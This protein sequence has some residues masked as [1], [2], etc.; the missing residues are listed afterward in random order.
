MENFST[1]ISKLSLEADPSVIGEAFVAKTERNLAKNL[2][3]LFG[4]TDLCDLPDGFVD[5]FTEM[6]SDLKTEYY[7]PPFDIEEG[8]EKRFEECLQRANRRLNKIINESFEEIN[9]SGIHAI[10]GLIHKNKIYLSQI[11]HISAFLFHQRKQF[12]RIIIDILGVGADKKA[13]IDHEKMFSNIVSGAISEKDD[14]IICNSKVLEAV[15]QYD[16]LGLFSESQAEEVIPVKLEKLIESIGQKSNFYAIII[17]PD[18]E[19]V[20]QQSTGSLPINKNNQVP[21]LPS[22]NS[23]N[24]LLRTQ[25]KTEKYLT[26][27][28]MPSWQKILILLG[29]GIKK[30]SIFIWKYL[31]IVLIYINNYARKLFIIIK[32]KLF[33]KSAAKEIMPIIPGGASSQI[34]PMKPSE[35]FSEITQPDFQQMPAT[36]PLNIIS[37]WVNGQIAKIIRLNKLQKALLILALILIFAFSESIVWMGQASSNK[38]SPNDPQV[39]SLQI[40]DKL[41]LAEAQNI[42]NDEV[43]A[44]SYLQQARD[45][46]AK[47]PEKKKYQ[48]MRSDLLSKI[49]K[50]SQTIQKIS[51]LENPQLITDLT[52]DNAQ[53]K[54]M[55]LSGRILFVY[56][57]GNQILYQIDLD[58]KQINKSNI[59]QNLNIIKI[60][61]LD[62]KNLIILDNSGNLFKYTLKASTTD[63][64]LSG[65]ASDVS[66]YAGKIYILQK[67]KNQIIK[68][69]LVKN[70]L[71]TPSSLI[72]N[73]YNLANTSAISATVSGVLS[74]D[75]SG[76]IKYF[77]KGIPDNMPFTVI[78][79]AVKP[80]VQ[81]YGDSAGYIYLL[82]QTNKKVIIY[83]K[84]GELK[85]QI[86]STQFNSLDGMAVS[87]KDKKI[88]LLSGSKI[89]AI[90][91]NL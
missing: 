38:K 35:K 80:P 10:I 60:A 58:K 22:Q 39:I 2:G 82:D 28:L 87:E 45:L 40:E 91:T 57:N 6:I 74:F 78:D 33:K 85:V 34:E 32:N 52:A 48:S 68:Y 30:T 13:K 14:I 51:Y 23:I 63:P 65:S 90:N 75:N 55:A 83:D 12:D 72:K 16:L 11:G 77:K 5:K 31:K 70:K 67:D 62:A 59:P 89:F 8:L 86:T 9:L 64:L 19:E 3:L 18:I 42:F 71:S 20:T 27:S 43:G 53:I 29:R 73:N 79:P 4:V 24:K 21:S 37:N 1:K 49:E 26:P 66:L 56:G 15:S 17:Q 47:I 46:L 44:K 41:S 81:I 84:K 7:L 76:Q 50:L 36:N 25:E 61:S 54:S 69:S 88:Y